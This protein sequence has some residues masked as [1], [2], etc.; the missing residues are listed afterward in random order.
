MA[1]MMDGRCQ[2]STVEGL[3]QKKKG[4]LG[5]KVIYIWKRVGSYCCP[6]IPVLHRKQVLH[7]NDPIF[8]ELKRE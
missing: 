5:L 2:G 3:D 4:F 1:D 6:P 7:F 8:T